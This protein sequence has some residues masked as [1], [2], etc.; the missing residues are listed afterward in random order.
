M[1]NKKLEGFDIKDLSD[2]DLDKI[3]QMLEEEY[4]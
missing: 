3:K 1:G 2:R 4:T